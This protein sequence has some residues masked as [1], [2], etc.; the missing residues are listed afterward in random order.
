MS[1]NK[2]FEFGFLFEFCNLQAF[3]LFGS[4]HS[5]MV[6]DFS[7]QKAIKCARPKYLFFFL[8]LSI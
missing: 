2:F 4:K 6:F 1:V 3:G 5:E 8:I 7:C